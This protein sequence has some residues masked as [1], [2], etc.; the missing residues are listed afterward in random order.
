M[1]R[2]KGKKSFNPSK[3]NGGVPKKSSSKTYGRKPSKTKRATLS[4]L[5]GMTAEIMRV[6]NTNPT[7]I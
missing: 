5:E 2:R 4:T 3:E 7:K 1:A 6:F